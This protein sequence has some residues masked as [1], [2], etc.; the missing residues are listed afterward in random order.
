MDVIA[1]SSDD[2]A[3]ASTIAEVHRHA[4]A[5]GCDVM[6]YLNGLGA[7][8][9]ALFRGLGYR[10][11]SEIYDLLIWPREMSQEAAFQHISHWR[12][13]FGDHDTF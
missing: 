5:R 10:T 9:E 2:V 3:V 7:A 1:D 12:F 13:G 4:A 11:S 6:L 8:A